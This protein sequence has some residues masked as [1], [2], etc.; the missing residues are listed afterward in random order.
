MGR[1]LGGD[2][3]G[4]QE[5]RT[6]ATEMGRLHKGGCKKGGWANVEQDDK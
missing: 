6:T 5:K 2:A 3:G 4:P 1:L